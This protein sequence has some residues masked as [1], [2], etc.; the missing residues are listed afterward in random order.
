M[1][2]LS[3]AVSGAG[4][5]LDTITGIS[6]SSNYSF[7]SGASKLISLGTDISGSFIGDIARDVTKDA[8]TATG[9]SALTGGGQQSQ[10]LPA[11]P[12]FR[13]NT[14]SS[15][16]PRLGGPGKV[17]PY[18]G[19]QNQRQ[20]DAWRQLSNSRNPRIQAALSAVRPTIVRKGVTK[21]LKEADITPRRR[22]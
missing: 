19:T 11:L 5:W 8:V 16:N 18:V 15:V 4:S 6:P 22:S 10:G 9:V 21:T 20:M 3:D 12:Q 14:S 2:W 13:G 17:K 1:S 7:S